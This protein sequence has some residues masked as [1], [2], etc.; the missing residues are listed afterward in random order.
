M[1]ADSGYDAVSAECDKQ[2]L[3]IKEGELEMDRKGIA[4][5]ILTGIVIGLS[6]LFVI[7][8]K[9][10]K[11][12][13]HAP[14]A[15]LKKQEHRYK[16]EDTRKLLARTGEKYFRHE[17]G[18][19]Y[20]DARF[21]ENKE[22]RKA[23]LT[24]ETGQY[25]KALDLF[26]DIKVDSLNPELSSRAYFYIASCLQNMGQDKKALLFL[27]RVVQNLRPTAYTTK[28]IILQGEINRKYQY[29]NQSLEIY[30][31]KLYM[32]TPKADERQQILTQLGYLKLFRNDLDGA[33]SQFHRSSTVLS[34]LGQARVHVRRSEYWKSISIYEDLLKHRNF[35]NQPYFKDISR[36]FQ[37]QTYHYAKRWM[38]KG[39]LDHAYFYF[40]KIVNFFPNSMYGEASLYHIGNIFLRRKLY[41]SAIRYYNLVLKNGNRNKN[42]AAQFKKGI[43]YY[44]M[45][46]TGAALRNLELVRQY[47]SSSPYYTVAKQWITVI[48]RDLTYR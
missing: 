22:Y 46:K 3:Q 32:E 34:R 20:R 33:L 39:D 6:V 48:E 47:Y 12:G 7:S 8:M 13:S 4:I 27:N 9:K 23:V 44:K 31:H 11:N 2:E 25:K 30:L 35:Q 28:A 1:K 15:D 16:N 41:N 5:G 24:Y 19:L 18:H 42:A 38:D 43:A 17:N 14:V 21:F 37:K 29:S 45:R 26:T 40:R 10:N 36:A